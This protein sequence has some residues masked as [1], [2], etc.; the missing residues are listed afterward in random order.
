MDLGGCWSCVS[1]PKIQS[2]RQQ[3]K[4]S[5]ISRPFED[6]GLRAVVLTLLC[7]CHV[8]D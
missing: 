2:P 4:A 3:Q 7:L 6:S 5:L 1:L 8:A